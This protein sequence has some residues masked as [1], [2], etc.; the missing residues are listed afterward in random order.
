MVVAAAREEDFSG[1]GAATFWDD[2]GFNGRQLVTLQ[3]T[4]G[5]KEG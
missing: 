1:I 5:S 4:D 2:C 3:A